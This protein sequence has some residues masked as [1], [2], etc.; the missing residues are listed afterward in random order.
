MNTATDSSRAVTAPWEAEARLAAWLIGRDESGYRFEQV[1]GAGRTGLVFRGRSVDGERPVALKLLWPEVQPSLQGGAP[2]RVAHPGV[3]EV[4]D[5]FRLHGYR[6]WVREWLEG[7][8]ASALAGARLSEA[9]VL[10][11]LEQLFAALE[12]VHARGLLHRDLRP[13]NVFLCDGPKPRVKLLDLGLAPPSPLQSDPLRRSLLLAAPDC[14]APEQ[15]E[16]RAVGPTA[17]LY[18]VGCLSFQL[19]SGRGPFA[20]ADPTDTIFRHVSQPTP[21]LGAV[22]QVGPP[23]DAFVYRLMAKQPERRPQT[24]AECSR[25]LASVRHGVAAAR[26]EVELTVFARPPSATVTAPAPAVPDSGPPPDG[27]ARERRA[28]VAAVV[29]ALIGLALPVAWPGGGGHPPA[30]ATIEVVPA[31]ELPAPR[32]LPEPVP[33]A[34]PEPAASSPPADPGWALGWLLE[35]GAHAPAPAPAPRVEPA[36]DSR[37]VAPPSPARARPPVAPAPTSAA[38]EARL[39]V[40]EARLQRGQAVHGSSLEPLRMLLGSTRREVERARTDAA[41]RSAWRAVVEL[42]AEVP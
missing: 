21:H 26:R 11:C 16:G 34:R 39:A 20:G 28:M 32:R 33:V 3:V 12:A 14:L 36:P 27:A 35:V 29:L 15:V 38:L 5:T 1:A 4:V 37:A 7:H 2:P 25:I 19:L 23:L 24:S 6:C 42:E 8:P 41:R 9:A 10:D 30:A 31:P 13:S 40:L 18:A 22:A 17:D